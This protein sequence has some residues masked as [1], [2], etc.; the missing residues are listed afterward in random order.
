MSGH[1][2]SHAASQ[3]DR[4]PSGSVLS[5][6]FEA[7]VF[8][9]QSVFRDVM[10]A[11]ARPGTAVDLASPAQPPAPLTAEAGAVALVL[12]DHETPVW[13]DQALSDNSAIA[14]WL[15]FHTNAPLVDVPNEAAFAFVCEP[16]G[17]PSLASFALGTAEYP[18]RSTTVIIAVETLNGRDG[19]EIAGPGIR[20]TARLSPQPLPPAFWDQVRG[21]HA[22]FPRGVDILFTARGRIAGLPRST[23]ILK[24]E[25]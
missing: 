12:L 25:A 7:P 11:L 20:Q 6:G 8:D 16:S 21:N 18:D 14:D 13:C 23:R 22:L 1:T 5:G 19:A 4:S 9:A 24:P 3:P 15:R 2:A 17:M 10:T